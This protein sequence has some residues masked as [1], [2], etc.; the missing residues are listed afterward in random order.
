MGFIYR[1]LDS[2]H[3]TIKTYNS[4]SVLKIFH[5]SMK[6]ECKKKTDSDEIKIA[7]RSIIEKLWP[8]LKS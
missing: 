5:Q 6:N 2:F 8:I 3:T 4:F 1:L 7:V